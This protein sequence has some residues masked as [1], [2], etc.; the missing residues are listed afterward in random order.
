MPIGIKNLELLAGI[1]RLAER[2]SVNFNPTMTVQR[3]IGEFSTQHQN[4]M[5]G[6]FEQQIVKHQ[7][8]KQTFTYT[9]SGQAP[10]HGTRY[11]SQL[12]GLH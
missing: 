4:W 8:A 10:H 1:I 11:V 9:E 3:S 6:E 12:A 5:I 7:G 2:F